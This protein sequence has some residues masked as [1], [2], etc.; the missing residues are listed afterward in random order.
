MNK[1]VVLSICAILSAPC[2]SCSGLGS[3]ALE[4]LSLQS[5][6]SDDNQ[7]S[8]DGQQGA[9]R[10]M[11]AEMRRI[12]PLLNVLT[13]TKPIES[14]VEVD[15]STPLK[16]LYSELRDVLRRG[17]IER[18]KLLFDFMSLR[19]RSKSELDQF[20]KAVALESVEAPDLQTEPVYNFLF[21]N[22]SRKYLA[23][24]IAD[25]YNFVREVSANDR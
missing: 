5:D 1:L 16:D 3:K 13:R 19:H 4:G 15:S 11:M 17:D 10:R 20:I 23:K 18:A 21:K 14:P 7:M 6:V 8:Y 24:L 9:F 12:D 2:S 22:I 25:A